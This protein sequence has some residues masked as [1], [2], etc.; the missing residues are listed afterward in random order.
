M[1]DL[2]FRQRTA[3]IRAAL[4]TIADEADREKENLLEALAMRD[5]ENLAL[6][7]RVEALEAELAAALRAAGAEE[8]EPRRIIGYRATWTHPQ[9]KREAEI[10]EGIAASVLRHRYGPDLREV[11]FVR[12]HFP[13]REPLTISC[14]QTRRLQR[15]LTETLAQAERRL[16]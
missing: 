16:P 11:S 5:E 13:N 14:V 7:A 6:A 12:L 3:A 8:E 2:T 4:S 15:I 10:C 1:S 9:G